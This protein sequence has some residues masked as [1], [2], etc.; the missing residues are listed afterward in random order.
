MDIFGPF[1]TATGI[2]PQLISQL[3]CR[4]SEQVTYILVLHVFEQPQLSVGSLCMDVGLEGSGQ[5]LHCYFLVCLL[6]ER[7]AERHIEK[8][9]KARM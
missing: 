2:T 1:A 8:G 9:L 4:R 5:L 7:R 6:I 3:H